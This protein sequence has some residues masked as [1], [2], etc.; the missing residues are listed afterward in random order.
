MSGE[1]K[2]VLLMRVLL[3]NASCSEVSWLAAVTEVSEFH[4]NSRLSSESLIR[5]RKGG[6][7]RTDFFMSGYS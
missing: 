5:E 6:G 3:K 4:S 1:S 7:R 2:Q